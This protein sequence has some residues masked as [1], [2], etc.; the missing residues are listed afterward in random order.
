MEMLLMIDAARGAGASRI[1]AVVPHFAHA[2]SDK[3]D[4]PRISLGGR[5][6]ADMIATAGADRVLTMD[7]HSPQVHGFFSVPVDHLTALGVLAEH[8]TGID[9]ART[10]VVSP[11]LGGAKPADA[12]ARMLGV[13]VAAGSKKR[14]A[15]DEVV[16]DSIVGDVEGRDVIVLD[17]EIATGGSVCELLDVLGTHGV[18]R[19]SLVCTHGLFTGPA[20]E[21][22][23][24]RTD[25]TSVVTTDTVP[26]DAHSALPGFEVRSVAPLFAETIRRT[27]EG[28]SVSELFPVEAPT[29]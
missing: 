25:L 15:D 11:D 3:K 6:V 24:G 14:I 16:I 19:V 18:G 21:R 13:P 22:L 20:V 4:A 12:F 7:L 10:V 8:F 27:H 9:L 23:C 2:R 26:Q 1:T 17:D 28:E 5:L 29:H